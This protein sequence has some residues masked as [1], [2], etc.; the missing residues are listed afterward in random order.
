MCTERALLHTQLPTHSLSLSLRAQLGESLIRWMMG[1][2]LTLHLPL[3]LYI[4]SLYSKLQHPLDPLLPFPSPLTMTLPVPCVLGLFPMSSLASMSCLA[5]VRNAA[6]TL[7]AFLADVSKNEM[8]RPSANF[9]ASSVSTFL[10]S[11]KSALF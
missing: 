4:I 5:M 3:L 9:L 1:R 2:G 6:S 10:S 8:E 11:F 7:V